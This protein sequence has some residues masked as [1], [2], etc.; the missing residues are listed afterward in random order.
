MT[1]GDIVD[2]IMNSDSVRFISSCAEKVGNGVGYLYNTASSGC[3]RFS[4]YVCT[5]DIELPDCINDSFSG[6]KEMATDY[7]YGFAPLLTPL[8]VPT[9]IRKGNEFYNYVLDNPTNLWKAIPLALGVASAAA[10]TLS[11]APQISYIIS[12]ALPLLGITNILDIGYEKTFASRN[13]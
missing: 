8:A 7:L 6:L 13:P 1:L 2:D 10:L 5:K 9:A 12:E 3:D 4:E 11:Y